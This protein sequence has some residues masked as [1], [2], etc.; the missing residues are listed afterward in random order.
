MKCSYEQVLSDPSRR[1]AF[2]LIELLVVIGIISLLISI[3]LPAISRAR[4][5]AK[6]VQCS[7]NLHQLAIATLM[8]SNDYRGVLPAAF[9][10][11]VYTSD[12]P[13]GSTYWFLGLGGYTNVKWAYLPGYATQPLNQATVFADPARDQLFLYL[14]YGLHYGYNQE[15]SARKLTSIRGTAK[16]LIADATGYWFEVDRYGYYYAGFNWQVGNQVTL[17]FKRHRRG[18]NI[19]FTDGHVETIPTKIITN[20]MLTDQQ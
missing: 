17:D 15:F 1:S 16:G 2:T 11:D 5:Q 12:I 3:L 13:A 9:P 18:L 10:P 4:E 8:Y 20:Q 19:S 7:S 14:I 6:T